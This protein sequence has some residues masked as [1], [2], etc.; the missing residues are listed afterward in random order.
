MPVFISYRIINIFVKRQRQSFKNLTLLVLFA[1]IV[2]SEAAK[3]QHTS[4][5]AA[6]SYNH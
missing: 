3:P 2:V 1:L 5:C 4:V 6:N